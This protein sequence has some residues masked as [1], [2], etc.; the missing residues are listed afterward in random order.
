MG[1]QEKINKLTWNTPFRLVYGKEVVI[2]MD[3]I[4]PSPHI[5]TINDLSYFGAI[6]EIL[7]QSVQLEEDH[8]V[9]GFHKQVQKAREK[10]WNDRNI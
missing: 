5:T 2:P 10:E 7:S 4:L 6:E 1:I 8:F 3:F 9:T